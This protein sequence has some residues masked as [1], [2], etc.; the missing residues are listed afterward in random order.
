MKILVDAGI[1][2]ASRYCRGD[3]SN[4]RIPPWNETTAL[5]GSKPIILRFCEDRNKSLPFLV[6]RIVGMYNTGTNA[7]KKLFHLNLVQVQRNMFRNNASDV[8]KLRLP[9]VFRNNATDRHTQKSNRELIE[10][11]NLDS[12]KHN[13]VDRNPDP[14]GGVPFL[15][16]IITRDPYRWMRSTC[17]SPYDIR[18][19][20]VEKE[21]GTPRKI[22]TTRKRWGNLK[23][24]TR[25][26]P[27]N[28]TDLYPPHLQKLSILFPRRE[29]SDKTE[30]ESHMFNRDYPSLPHMWSQWHQEYLHAAESSLSQQPTLI[31]RFEDVLVHAPEVLQAVASCAGMDLIGNSAEEATSNTSRTD[32]DSVIKVFYL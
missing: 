10:E 32:D 14:S 24:T 8:D 9:W 11:L 26:K 7:L 16:V 25:K 20:M 22:P 6:P 17:R 21:S 1:Q 30:R 2:N 23:F 3:E 12:L 28:C 5:Y 4:L 31:I 13:P 15:R 27:V 29:A 19:K 18:W